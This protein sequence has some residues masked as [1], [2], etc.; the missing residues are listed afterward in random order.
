MPT[1]RRSAAEYPRP[2]RPEI[3]KLI[4]ND[5][6]VVDP[7]IKKK[8]I[9]LLGKTGP[10]AGVDRSERVRLLRSL[11]YPEPA[12][13]EVLFDIDKTSVGERDGPRDEFE[14]LYFSA[15]FLIR[16]P[17]PGIAATSRPVSSN[18]PASGAS[19]PTSRALT[20]P[21]TPR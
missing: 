16:Q 5:A 14:A 20:V 9:F 3:Y 18:R 10:Y 1:S 21:G 7:S 2:I 15:L 17:P 4:K 13:L 12:I 8:A 6:G 19:S 11:G